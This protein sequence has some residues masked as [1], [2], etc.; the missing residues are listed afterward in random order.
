MQEYVIIEQDHAEIQVCR[1]KDHWQS[2]YYYLGEEIIFESIGVT[3]SVED[4]YYQVETADVLEYLQS[5]SQ[6]P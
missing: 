3:V 2:Y 5:K 6:I 1:R 4:I